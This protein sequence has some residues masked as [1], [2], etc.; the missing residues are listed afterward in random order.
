MARQEEDE[1]VYKTNLR[2]YLDLE[3][4]E[5]AKRKNKI[6]QFDFTQTS[7]VPVAVTEGEVGTDVEMATQVKGRRPR[8][9]KRRRHRKRCGG[10]RGARGGA[11]ARCWTERETEVVR[12]RQEVRSSPSSVNVGSLHGAGP[13]EHWEGSPVVVLAGCR[14]GGWLEGRWWRLQRSGG[15]EEGAFDAS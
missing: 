14:C 1:E 8:H 11:K 2:S 4:H 13:C 5:A 10:G 15:A 6:I 9:R 3:R 7:D 12:M